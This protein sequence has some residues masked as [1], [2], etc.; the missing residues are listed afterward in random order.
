M[1]PEEKE[2][3]AR[4][5]ENSRYSA[6]VMQAAISHCFKVFAP[7]FQGPRLLELGPAEGIMTALLVETDKHITVV[8]G[9]VLFCQ[10]LRR[11]FPQIDVVHA[12]F[13][14]FEPSDLFDT[15]V[16]GHVLE[17]VHD[18]VDILRRA[19]RWLAPGGKI[20]AAVPNALSLHRQAAVLMGLLP[21]TDSLNEMDLQ[22]GHR[23]V[24][25]PDRFRDIF[26]RAE[27]E[28]EFF[29][30]YWLKPLANHQIETQW[31]AAMIDAFMHLGER[32]PEIAGEIYI[33]ASTITP[34][35]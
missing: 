26:Q 19:G 32:H 31:T 2:T 20:L 11:C 21:E 6:G 22:H 23:R 28:I 16:L 30:G 14:E 25:D 4:L 15:I 27:L 34:R 17:H 18:P 35:A 24:F 3:L 33:V 29:G 9:S 7:Y 1:I 13:E 5:S 10:N 12:L 8:E